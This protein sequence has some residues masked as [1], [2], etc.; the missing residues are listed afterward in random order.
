MIAAQADRE[1]LFHLVL[2]EERET[3]RDALI[4]SLRK[5]WGDTEETAFLLDYLQAA[6]ETVD[7]LRDKLGIEKALT[8]ILCESNRE[9]PEY[10]SPFDET[11]S[12]IGGDVAALKPSVEAQHASPHYGRG[13]RLNYA[14]HV[15]LSETS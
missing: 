14:R 15:F 9:M 2:I 13:E 4:A 10:F 8:L 6:W 1:A 7:L 12:D 5:E 11:E 3:T